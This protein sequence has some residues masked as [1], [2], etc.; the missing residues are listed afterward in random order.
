M[1]NWF[2]QN[3][4]H[5][6]IIGIFFAISFVYF[7]PAFK[8]KALGESDVTR[9]QSTQKEIMDYHEKD[10]TILWTN[11]VLGGMPTF[12]LWAHYPGNITTHI[13]DVLKKVFPNPIDTVLLLLLGSY[14]LF[15]VLKL[16]PWLAAAGAIAFTFSSYNFILMLAGHSNQVFAI[17]FFAPIL[18]GII[19]ALR[20]KY[21]LG[22]ALTALFLALEIRANHVQMTY[23]LLLA[24]VI[25]VLVELYHA[26]KAKTLASFGKA[27]AYLAVG[28]LLAIAVNASMLW[29]TYDYG[30]D[31]IR[32]QSNLT[33]NT[34]QP[35][36]GLPR[37]Y[38]YEYSQGIGECLTFLIPNAYGGY[39]G[40]APGEGSNVAKAL[41]SN[42]VDPTQA[43]TFAQ[44][45]SLYWGDKPF[46][47]GPN[48][49]GA[50]IF[51]LFVFGL[52]IVRSQVKWWLV[53]AIVLSVVLSFGR[54]LSFVSDIFFNYFPLYNKFRAVDSFLAIAMLCVPVLALL[55]VNEVATTT[56]RAPLFK[57]LLIALY[58][59]GGLCLVIIIL[60]DLFLPFK[61]A[62]NQTIQQQLTQ[63]FKGNTDA[64]NAVMAGL[65]QDRVSVA[66]ADAARSLVFVLLAFAL[67]WAF[68]KQKLNTT[69]VSVAFLAIILVDLWSVDKRY[70]K[71]ESFIDKQDAQAPK[72]RDIDMLIMRDKD[73]DYRVF[74]TTQPI[75]Q[76]A[77]TPYFHKAISGYTAARLKRFDELIDNQLSKS[78]NQ[79]V[80]DMLNVKY[81][82][83]A[84]EKNQ[85]SISMHANNTACGHAWFVKTVKFAPNADEEMQAISSFDPSDEAIVD[86]Q[87]STLID[88]K[89]NSLD[90][91]GKIDLVSYNPDHM[92]YQSGSTTQEIAIFSEIYYNKGWKMYIDGVEKPYFRA[93]YVLRAAQI[94]VGNHKIEFIF[95]PT[96]YYAGE[97]ISFAS[98]ILL[99]LLLGG[100]LFMETKKKQPVATPA[101]K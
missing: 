31:T 65:T 40:N 58:I 51:F 85:G 52:I 44:Q 66:R 23:Y 18:A 57:K 12:Q 98:S 84:D 21:L 54:N 74:D 49:Y 63:A 90:T 97:K 2:K 7:T 100:A 92:V 36:N 33:Q 99:V 25:L 86:K 81:I 29:S 35:S 45:F 41:V 46:T 71:D 8:G 77:V 19:L 24:I 70:L 78:I 72:P 5:L 22:A 3:G 55:A 79:D 75:L 101:K 17:A 69:L 80:L 11:Q 53:G 61:N 15:C 68:I 88:E 67:L 56:D 1:N 16:N 95:H 26:Y 83:T 50:V 82:L 42:N 62:T 32:G 47:V 93:D 48:Y 73:P 60:P 30:K 34:K 28:T 37:D 10:T 27:L 76:D 64:A 94:P 13:I 89:Q 39:T 14:L 87:Y 96:S 59:T 38:A 91:L 4:I 9:A 6:A 20:G 43:E